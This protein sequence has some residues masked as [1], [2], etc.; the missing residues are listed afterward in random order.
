MNFS[1]E[2]SVFII[3]NTVALE[4]GVIEA[5]QETVFKVINARIENKFKALGG[6]KGKYEL[7]AG[8]ADATTFAPAGWPEDKDGRYRACYKLTA[9]ETDE[10]A[11]WLSSAF[12]INGAKLCL[13]FW[14]HGGL[15]GRTKG[16]VERKLVTVSNAAAVKDAGMIRDEDNTIYLPFALDA[17]T[18]A[19]E[20][21]AVDK[22]LAPLD[23]A[24]DKLLK[25]HPQ[26]DAAVKDLA[27]K[28]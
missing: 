3:K 13:R 27:T 18:L 17:E 21:P 4:A 22:V 12:G 10:N 2:L 20:Y 8:E 16:E 7:V 9:L 5:V 11:Y 19:A 15:A 14:V 28:K 6:W 1:K 26:F 24:L 23:A 25:A